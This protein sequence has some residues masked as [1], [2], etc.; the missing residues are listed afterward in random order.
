MVF[1]S[2]GLKRKHVASEGQHGEGHEGG[3]LRPRK[4]HKVTFK[5]AEEQPLLCQDIEIKVSQQILFRRRSSCMILVVDMRLL[6]RVAL[7]VRHRRPSPP[8]SRQGPI[9]CRLP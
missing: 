7:L 1:Q 6:E 9:F 4:V 5:L 2:Y 8:L 3:D